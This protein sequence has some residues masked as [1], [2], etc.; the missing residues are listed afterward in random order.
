[1]KRFWSIPLMLMLFACQTPK[2]SR[3]ELSLAGCWELRLDSTDVTEQVQLPGTTDTNQKGYPN[4][5]KEETTHLSRPFRY[6]GKAWYQKEITIPE[7]WEG[8][9]IWLILERT[10]PTQIWVDSIYVG[11]SDH[12]STPQEYDLSTYLRAGKHHLTILV[13]NGL[14]VPPQLLDNSHAYTESTQTNWNGIIG[15]LKLEARPQFHIRRIQVYPHADQKTVDV[16]IKLS[17]PFEQ[18]IV[19]AVQIEM[20]AFNTGLEHHIKFNKNI[21]VQQDEIIFQIPMGD[22]ALEWSEFSPTLYR[23]TANIQGENIQDSQST[24][25]GLRDFKAE[26]T[27]FNINGLTTFLRGKHDACV[28]P[29]TG[30]V[31][32]DTAAWRRYF[33]IA[34]EYGINHCRFHS[35]CPPKACFEAADI[36]GFYLQPELPFWGKMEKGDTTLIHFLTKEGLQIQEAYGN[37]AS[38]VMMAI[39]N[40]L[41]GDQEAMVDM[42]ARFRSEDGRH[43]YASGSNDYLGF[44]GPA[45]GDD[46]FTT[47]RVPGANVFSNHTRGSFSFADA[48]DGGYINH[49]YPNSVMNFESAIEQCSLPII[50][51]ETGQFQCYPNYEEIKKYTGALKP[52]NLEI[53]RKRLGESGMAGQADDFF[54]ASGKWMAQLYRAEMEMAFRTPGMAGFQLLDLQDYPGQGSAYVGILD[55]FMDSKGLVEPKKWREFC[56]EVVPLLT[57]AKFCWTGGESFAGTVEIANYGETSLNGK[58]ISWELKNGKKSLGKGK[59]A[60]PSGLGLLTAGTIRLTL[61]DVEQAYKVELLLKVSG[62][63]YQNS[64][65][66]WIYPAKKQLKAGNVVVAR[67]LTDDVLNALKQGGKVLLMPRGEDCKEVT[68]GGLFQTDYWNYRMFKSICDRIKKPASPGTLGILT[69]PEHPVFDDFPTEYHTNWQ[70]YPIIKHSYPLILDG[71]PK[72]YRPI[73]QVIDNVERNHKLGLL[74]ELNVEGSKLLLCMSDLEAVRDTPEG[75][76]F[77]AALLAYMNSSDFKPSTSLSVESFKN[78]FETGVRKEGIKVLDNISYE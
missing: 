29:L 77:Y 15:D 78:L 11:S 43:L 67:Q 61:P 54:K 35:W 2:E 47:C 52:W 13:D 28:F 69:N 5:D 39:G 33:R 71:M 46:Y 4:N 48:E 68:V 30:H 72:E 27:Q 7:N 41:S 8:K 26:G 60:I 70:W 62:T 49:T 16:K 59:M 31:P 63:S 22:D 55:A 12:I 66:L 17:N 3:E 1:M 23:L 37:H 58:S 44:N 50:G 32:M 45:A 57:T 64:Y 42:I 73:V 40:E 19:A 38:F 18:M 56:S 53:F 20:E 25:F 65:P 6:Q 24:T 51:H 75:L 21:V 10:K 14:S 9:S 36:E 34:K 74:M 76:Q